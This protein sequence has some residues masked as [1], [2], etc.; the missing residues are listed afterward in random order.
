VH[1]A[2]RVALLQTL[3]GVGPEAPTLC[4]PWS[5]MRL[6]AHIVDSERG[7]GAGWAVGWPLR[8]ALGPRLA[9][10]MMRRTQAPMLAMMD[11]TERKGWEWILRRLESGPPLFFR[12]ASL[13]R[14]RLLEDFIHHEDIRR[15]NGMAPRSTTLAFDRALTEGLRTLARTPEFAAERGT[16]RVETSDGRV[17]QDPEGPAMQLRGAV[18]ELALALAGRARVADVSIDGDPSRVDASSLRI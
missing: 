16:I 2:E 14:I 6:A 11:R 12:V 4:E 1:R 3:R 7:G 9:P 18:S 10:A 13:A 8:R 17:L 5:A 15:A